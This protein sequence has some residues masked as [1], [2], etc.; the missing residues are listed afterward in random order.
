[1]K[2]FVTIYNKSLFEMYMF[3]AV[4]DFFFLFC[5]ILIGA[6]SIKV[7]EASGN[8]TELCDDISTSVVLL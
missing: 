8:G 4:T 6:Q 5:V 7:A 1:M 2:W 3:C